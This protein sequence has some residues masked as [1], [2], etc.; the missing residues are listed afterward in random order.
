MADQ[1]HD[2][3]A[4]N[5]FHVHNVE[6]KVVHQHRILLSIL[7]P[8]SLLAENTGIA[9]KRPLITTFHGG[10]LIGGSRLFSPWIAPWYLRDS[11]VRENVLLLDQRLTVLR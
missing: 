11:L 3:T 8:K 1:K 9:S 4:F 10:W 5:D 7:V 6:Y 2:P